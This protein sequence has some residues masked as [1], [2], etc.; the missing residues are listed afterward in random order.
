MLVLPSLAV[1]C[2]R[3]AVYATTAALRP[4]ERE[5]ILPTHELLRIPLPETVWKLRVGSD[6]RSC[7]P[8]ERGVR[9]PF[10]A[11][12]DTNI[13]RSEPSSY[14]PDSLSTHSAE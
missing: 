10:G 2:R 9:V 11:L 14:F 12:D 4:R 6:T 3:K 8:A 1:C 13:A 5:E 7:E